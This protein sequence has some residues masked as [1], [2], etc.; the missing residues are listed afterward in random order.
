V[1]PGGL[2]I[3]DDVSSPSV[4]TALRYFDVNLGWRPVDIA[5]R[6][7]ARLL[8]DEPFEPAFTEFKA[9]HE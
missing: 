6:L 8:P 3:L 9:F 7:S 5:G 1:R 2:I 4:A